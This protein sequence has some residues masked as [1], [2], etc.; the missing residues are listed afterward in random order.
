MRRGD[1]VT[2]ALQGDSGKPRP[3]VVVQTDLLPPRAKLLVVPLSSN[4]DDAPLSRMIVAPTSESGLK[5][6]SQLMFDRLTSTRRDRCSNAFGRL[7][8]AQIVELDFHLNL[9]FGLLDTKPSS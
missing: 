5:H 6:E 4:L 9:V 8:A 7:D 1:I 3:A 2:V